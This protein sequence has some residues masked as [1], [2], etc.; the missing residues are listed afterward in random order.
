MNTQFHAPHALGNSQSFQ[1][2]SCHFSPFFSKEKNLISM[3][4]MQKIPAIKE[5]AEATTAEKKEDEKILKS[6]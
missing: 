1:L 3:Q 4:I 6:N 2:V 5:E